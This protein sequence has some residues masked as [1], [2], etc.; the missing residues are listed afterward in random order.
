MAANNK[1]SFIF[2]IYI[3]IKS[4]NPALKSN[5]Y[6][7]ILATMKNDRSDNLDILVGVCTVY[8]CALDDI[9]KIILVSHIK[10]IEKVYPWCQENL[11]RKLAGLTT[12][13][14]A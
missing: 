7:A 6:V 2:L 4:K 12:K 10:N 11:Y 9:M 1:R 14:K 5:M 3:K 13:K 8:D